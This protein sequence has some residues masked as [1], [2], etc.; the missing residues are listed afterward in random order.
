MNILDDNDFSDNE[1]INDI[2]DIPYDILKE[3]EYDL[4]NNIILHYKQLLLKEPEFIG[5]K[6]I[7]SGFILEKINNLHNFN[8]IKCNKLILTNEQYKIFQNMF[9][10][11]QISYDENSI[12]ILANIIYNKISI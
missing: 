9:D 12:N 8:S 1:D 11:L 10:E 2:G 3:M 6:N 7:N 4:N 5:I